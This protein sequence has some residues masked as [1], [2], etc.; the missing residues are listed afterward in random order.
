MTR[1]LGSLAC[2]AAIAVAAPA[3][4]AEPG[5]GPQWATVNVCD[6]AGQPNVMGVRASLPGDGTSAQMFVRFTAQ[7]HD[8]AQKAWL[9]VGGAATSP[10]LS[11]GSARYVA[12]QAGWNFAFDAPPE[13][14]QYLLRA[15]AELQ[16]RNGATVTRSASLVTSSG[17]AAVMEGDPAGTSLASCTLR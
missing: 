1:V 14:G 6:S 7:W 5:P 16:W 3:S 4:A 15:V 12:R 10:W 9:P 2:A 17:M 11:A 8:N 13:G